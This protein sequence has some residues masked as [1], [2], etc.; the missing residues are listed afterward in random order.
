MMVVVVNMFTALTLI[1]IILASG[2][3]RLYFRR[4]FDTTEHMEAIEAA[5]ERQ[6]TEKQRL[7]NVK[8]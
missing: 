7:R 3:S 6:T 2:I 1:G 5:T 8:L 4:K